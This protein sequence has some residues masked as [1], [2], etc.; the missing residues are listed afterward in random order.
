[1]LVIGGGESVEMFEFPRQEDALPVYKSMGRIMGLGFSQSGRY[2]GIASE[3]QN[4]VV[5]NWAKREFVKCRPGHSSSVL[6]V[7]FSPDEKTLC[8][9]GLDGC[10]RI[11]KV[12]EQGEWAFVSNFTVCSGGVKSNTLTPSYNPDGSVLAVPG[13]QVLQQI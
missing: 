9:T 5:Y 8:S 1:M 3:E 10:V 2:L 13:K 7:V 11:Y 6:S 12:D 4:A